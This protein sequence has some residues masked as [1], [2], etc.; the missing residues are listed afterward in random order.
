MKTLSC[1]IGKILYNFSKILNIVFYF[2]EEKEKKHF[3]INLGKAEKDDSPVNKKED[4]NCKNSKEK[5]N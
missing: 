1:K 3:P 4:L 5:G 2:S